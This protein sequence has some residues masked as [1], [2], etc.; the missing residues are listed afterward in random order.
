MACARRSV[1]AAGLGAAGNPYDN[2]T[3]GSIIVA[4]EQLT[5]RTIERAYVNKDSAATM[6]PAR[7]ASSSPARG[8]ACSAGIKRELRRPSA[9]KPVIGHM[10]IDSHLRRRYPQR[11]RP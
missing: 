5:G 6:P 9:T 2:R 3:L 11:G 10:K 8:L 7:T 1:R 4:T